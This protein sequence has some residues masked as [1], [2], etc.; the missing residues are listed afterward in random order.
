M[1]TTSSGHAIVMGAGIAGLLAARVLRESYARVTIVERDRLPAA[2]EPRPGVPHGRHG[3]LLTA[4]GRLVIDDLCPGF[5]Q[6][7]TRAGIKT[8]DVCRDVRMQ[9]ATGLAPVTESGI[10]VQPASRPL[11][12]TVLR[13]LTTQ[14]DN[15]TVLE[16]RTVTGLVT[17]GHLRRVSGVQLRSGE[18]LPAD[19]VVD[20]S[21]RTSHLRDWLCAHGA[22]RVPDTTVDVG[23]TCISRLYD[24]GDADRAWAERFKPLLGPLFNPGQERGGFILPIENNR[25]IVS[26]QERPGQ[27]RFADDA[28]FD[29]HASQLHEL[30]ADVLTPLRPLSRPIR[31]G[32]TMTRLI[33]YDAATWWPAGL[34]VVGDAV[35]TLNPIYAQG[36]TTAALHARLLRDTLAH[37]PITYRTREFQR[38]L[39]RQ[40]AW[41]W[42][43]ATS[44]D[45]AWIDH[46]KQNGAATARLL[47][48]FSCWY[49]DRWRDHIPHDPALYRAHM[50]MANMVTGPAA[51]PALTARILR[52]PPRGLDG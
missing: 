4:G 31:F 15:V 6:H 25:V 42:L 47:D 20:A 30:Y 2:A 11:L 43:V 35:C 46:A 9:F 16:D 10:L 39:R 14:A 19:L 40:L 26:L 44:S 36:M 45:Q 18:R 23:F 7:L 13:D 28:E 12:E 48:R 29:Q 41:P 38:R 8:L 33:Q 21:G 49:M 50:A 17:E 5:T 22:P 34:I 32:H 24:A 52:R 51:L 27:Q 3:H 37:G 1:P